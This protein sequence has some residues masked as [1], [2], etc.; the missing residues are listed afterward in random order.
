MGSRAA[1]GLVEQLARREDEGAILLRARQQL[2]ER[3][4]PPLPSL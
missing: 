1:V 2:A 4:L 3:A